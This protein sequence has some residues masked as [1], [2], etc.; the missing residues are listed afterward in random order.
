MS[1]E[2]K[3]DA[4]LE[5]ERILGKENLDGA[6]EVFIP[7]YVMYD[8][9]LHEERQVVAWRRRLRRLQSRPARPCSYR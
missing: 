3:L 9:G 4:R 6:D 1:V 5:P 7:D 8:F 2:N